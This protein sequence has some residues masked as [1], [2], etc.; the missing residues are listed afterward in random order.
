MNVYRIFN[1]IA[2]LCFTVLCNAQTPFPYLFKKEIDSTERL[3]NAIYQSYANYNGDFKEAL[4]KADEESNE[5]FSISDTDYRLFSLLKPVDA[6]NYILKQTATRQIVMFNEGHHYPKDRNFTASYLKELYSQGYRYFGAETLIKDSCYKKYPTRNS[7]FY[8]IEPAYGD[9][10]RLALETGFTVFAYEEDG[11]DLPD[12][13]FVNQEQQAHQIDRDFILREIAQ[14][15]HIHRI[16]EKDSAAKIVLHVGYGHLSRNNIMM[17]YYLNQFCGKEALSIDVTRFAE[18]SQ[19]KFKEPIVQLA[20]ISKPTLFLDSTGTPFC[21]SNPTI[22]LHVALPDVNYNNNR[23]DF[24]LHNGRQ[25]LMQITIIDTTLVYPILVL[26]YYAEEY[27]KE[28]ENAVAIDV[29][30]VA[31]KS[32]KVFVALPVKGKGLIRIRDSKN[33]IVE[34]VY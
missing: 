14:A 12:S 23:G 24:V 29:F 9:L 2:L 18:K 11:T 3:T 21:F 13:N 33:K 31:Q 28:G 10:I 22:D 6:H 27:L 8:S 7:G 15:H 34:K 20:N 5:V 4:K 32:E 19:N 25:K 16:L 1:L 17:A 26:A 30:E